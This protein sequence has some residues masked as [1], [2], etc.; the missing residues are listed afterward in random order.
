MTHALREIDRGVGGKLILPA[1]EL[2]YRKMK[3]KS[4]KRAW[5][6]SGSPEMMG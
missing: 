5:A 2:S 6:R 3:R 4:Q 1:D